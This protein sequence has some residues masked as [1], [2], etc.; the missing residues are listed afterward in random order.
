MTAVATEPRILIR[1][2]VPSDQA[3][4]ERF[5]AELSV[6]SRSARFLGGTT[7]LASGTAYAFCHP[8][9]AHRQGLV[10]ETLGPDG[11]RIV[12]HACLEPAAGADVEFA[13]AVADA[14]HHHGVGR[15]L[16]DAA[17]EW[18]RRRGV[19]RLVASTRWSNVAMLGL[20]R[21]SGHPVRMGP[22]DAGV[23]DVI[24]DLAEGL[25]SAA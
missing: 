1:A 18:A 2:I 21:S 8:D 19:G 11:W 6:D 12:G 10:A 14:W 3:A 22:D 7:A 5:Y 16:L 13:V 25:P 9:H 17:I 24:V 23:V 4:L 15:A 20:L